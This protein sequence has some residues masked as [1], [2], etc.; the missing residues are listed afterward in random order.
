MRPPCHVARAN[1]PP[2]HAPTCHMPRLPAAA[3]QSPGATVALLG[4]HPAPH[5]R[6]CVNNRTGTCT[7]RPPTPALCHFPASSQSEHWAHTDL[8]ITAAQYPLRALLRLC[9]T[10]TRQRPIGHEERVLPAR[11]PPRSVSLPVKI[12]ASHCIYRASARPGPAQKAGAASPQPAFSPCPLAAC[13]DRCLPPAYTVYC[14]TRQSTTVLSNACTTCIAATIRTTTHLPSRT[15]A[16][17][18]LCSIPPTPLHSAS[19]LP[20]HPQSRQMHA[21]THLQHYTTSQFPP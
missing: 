16:A 13:Q 17:R 4:G 15:P 8:P 9:R 18:Q 19:C 14:T 6:I 10:R 21:I 7:T 12:E 20:P 5:D 3:D 2:F 11:P 1:Q